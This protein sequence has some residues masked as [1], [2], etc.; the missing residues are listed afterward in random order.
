MTPGDLEY[1]P[2]APTEWTSEERALGVRWVI[3]NGERVLQEYWS[4]KSWANSSMKGMHGEWRDV[5]TET[6]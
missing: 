2:I 5:K 1:A 6:E 3:R 4:I